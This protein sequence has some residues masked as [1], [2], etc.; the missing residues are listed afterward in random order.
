MSCHQGLCVDPNRD[1]E[2]GDAHIN[3]KVGL[4]KKQ[5]TEFTGH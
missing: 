1:W 4:D 3:V 2:L 5:Q